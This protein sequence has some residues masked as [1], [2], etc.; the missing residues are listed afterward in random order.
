[1]IVP[2]RDRPAQLA[3]C[4]SALAAQTSPPGGF[5]VIVVDDG[6]ELDPELVL[7]RH[8]ASLPIELVRQP[9]A[10]PAVARNRGA[11]AAAARLIAFIDDDAVPSSGWIERLLRAHQESPNRAV[12]GPIV[13][14]DPSS[15]YSRATQA[16]ADSARAARSSGAPRFLS[17][18]NL[19]V[20]ADRLRELGGFDGAF[21]VSEDRELCD[22]W[23]ERGWGI[24]FVPE[25]VV[26]HEHPVSLTEFWRTHLHYGRGAFAYHRRRAQGGRL[27]DGLQAS[28]RT[29]RE[30]FARGMREPSLLPGIVVWQVGNACGAGLEAFASVRPGPQT[31][32][33]PLRARGRAPQP[34][35]E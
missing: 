9:P 14:L 24:R 28:R 17:A 31:A 11:E 34:S 2:T 5:E 25:A 13:A 33:L 23:L 6:G 4:L 10:G 29:L 19:A 32:S 27:G 22:R 7:D 20:P 35:L 18:C 16:I 21:H 12:G 1:M 15:A 3:R 30:A 8:R 26:W